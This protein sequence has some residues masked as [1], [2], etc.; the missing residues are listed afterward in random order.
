MPRLLEIASGENASISTLA[1]TLGWE[2]TTLDIREACKPDIVADVRTWDFKAFPAD[3]FQIVWASPPCD[4]LSQ[5]RSFKGDLEASD[6]VSK[7]VFEIL[8]YFKGGG[9]QV[10]CENPW[11]ALRRRPHVQEFKDKCNKVTYCSYDEGDNFPYAKATCIWNLSGSLWKP[12]TPCRN[13]CMFSDG[14][15]HFVWARHCG[16]VEQ[17]R[18][19]KEKGLQHS[20]KTRE[21]H[22]VP[23]ALCREILEA[24]VNE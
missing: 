14:K 17:N 18:I 2:T 19:C 24:Y 15:N 6:S 11:N 1:K 22:R 21:L 8:M 23:P 7:A 13:N 20:W 9:A 10:Y 4:Q 3:H 12:R 16:T 5:C